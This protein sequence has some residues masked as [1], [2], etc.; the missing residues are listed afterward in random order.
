M[1]TASAIFVSLVAVGR[2]DL[3]FGNFLIRM[4]PGRCGADLLIWS[5]LTQTVGSSKQI[6]CSCTGQTY[7]GQGSSCKR[8][9]TDAGAEPWCYVRKPPFCPSAQRMKG[10]PRWWWTTDC[11]SEAPQVAHAAPHAVVTRLPNRVISHQSK[12]VPQ[13]GCHCDPKLKDFTG[14]GGYCKKVTPMK[15]DKQSFTFKSGE[16]GGW[17][18]R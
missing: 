10:G 11:V 17:V 9:S 13:G 2:Q 14:S 5:L 12:L 6:G 8:W 15:L 4:V 18:G 1:A 7:K 16:R 3:P